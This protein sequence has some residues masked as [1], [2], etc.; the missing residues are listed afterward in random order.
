MGGDTLFCPE[1]WVGDRVEETMLQLTT[2]DRPLKCQL[3]QLVAE[4]AF[5]GQEGIAVAGQLRT[6]ALVKL[7]GQPGQQASILFSV[8]NFHSPWFQLG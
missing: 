7:N 8:P 6:P 1:V 5:G 2:L 3:K 4:V